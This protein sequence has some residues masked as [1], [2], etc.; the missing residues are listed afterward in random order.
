MSCRSWVVGLS[1]GPWIF[2]G[3]IEVFVKQEYL[4]EGGTS[5]LTITQ[6]CRFNNPDSVSYLES[7]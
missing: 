7:L 6:K 2:S 4:T 5:I 1:K 3:Y